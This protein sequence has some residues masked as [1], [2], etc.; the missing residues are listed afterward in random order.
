[1]SEPAEGPEIVTV[2]ARYANTHMSQ[3]V[4][5]AECGAVVRILDLRK[6]AVRAWI[7]AERPASLDTGWADDLK[8]IAARQRQAH[9]RQQAGRPDHQQVR[10]RIRAELLRNPGR[11]DRAVA[12]AVR[13][14][15][16][17]VAM[18]RREAAAEAEEAAS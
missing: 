17:T 1:M 2:S 12:R 18:V 6:P 10:Q 3:L 7:T 5:A 9:Q 11:S 8:L 4:A 14:S 15:S 16:R 13:A